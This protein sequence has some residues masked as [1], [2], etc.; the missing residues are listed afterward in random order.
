MTIT[1]DIC[2]TVVSFAHGHQFSG[3]GLPLNKAKTWWKN[4]M[5]SMHPVGGSTVL[6]YGHWHH[7]Q[8]LQDGPRTIFGCPSNDGGSRWFEERGGP[9]TACGTL[10]FVADKDGWHDLRIL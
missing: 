4:K 2:G 3:S 6:C 7:L 5:A 10:T 8:L 1:L 9:T